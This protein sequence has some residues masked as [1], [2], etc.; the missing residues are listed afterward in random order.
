MIEHLKDLGFPNKPSSDS[1]KAFDSKLTIYLYENLNIIPNEASKNE[2]WN[3]LTCE[4]L[5]DVVKWRFFPTIK[6]I[7]K[8]HI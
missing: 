1:L 3:F 5:P 8:K 4:L 6:N 2:V 7:P